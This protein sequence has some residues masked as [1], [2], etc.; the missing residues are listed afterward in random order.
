M[1]R[2][3]CIKT[4]ISHLLLKSFKPRY[5]VLIKSP[6]IDEI[7]YPMIKVLHPSFLTL[8]L[9]AFNRIYAEL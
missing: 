5:K 4:T 8:V 9:G 3:Q 6:G 7:T 1:S 2:K